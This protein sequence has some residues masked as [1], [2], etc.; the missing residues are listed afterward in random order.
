MILEGPEFKRDATQTAL[1]R[2]FN[3]HVYYIDMKLYTL[4]HWQS[5]D[6]VGHSQEWKERERGVRTI[7]LSQVKTLE[8]D[9]PKKGKMTPKHDALNR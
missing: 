2:V 5:K 9:N 3:I 6:K 8:S 1:M 7:A 4:F